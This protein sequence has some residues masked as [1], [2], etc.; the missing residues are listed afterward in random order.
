VPVLASTLYTSPS[1]H[2]EGHYERVSCITIMVVLVK[3]ASTMAQ[4]TRYC[5]SCLALRATFQ[6]GS[7]LPIFLLQ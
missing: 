5:H 3:H 6:V 4:T 7:L 2:L 1:S